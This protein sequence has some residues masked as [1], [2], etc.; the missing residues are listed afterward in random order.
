MVLLLPAG[1]FSQTSVTVTKVPMT[2]APVNSGDVELVSGTPLTTANDGQRREGAGGG[3]D[4]GGGTMLVACTVNVSETLL[5]W[6]PAS[7]VV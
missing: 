3:D 2:V 6:A 1:A 7:S 5:L 4:G